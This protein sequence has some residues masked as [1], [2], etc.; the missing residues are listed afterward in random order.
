MNSTQLSRQN[1]E[2]A[3]L[4]T[5]DTLAWAARTYPGQVVLGSS[6]GAEDQVL[7][8][9]AVR[10]GLLEGEQRIRPFTLDTGRLFPETLDL[11]ARS[12]A[13][14]GVRFRVYYPDTRELEAM[15][16]TGGIEL[17]RH[18]V[19]ERHRCC[20]VRKVEPLSRALQGQ[21]LWIVGLR[22]EQNANRAE[23]RR[24]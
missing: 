21:R 16:E 12:E 2:I 15:V 19:A 24:I 13:H 10:L 4:S 18:S 3:A 1:D 8:D 23:L 20:S 9:M 14:Y 5:A 22:S 17:F 6:L 11:L 7:L